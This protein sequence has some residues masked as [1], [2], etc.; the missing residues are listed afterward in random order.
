VTK[1]SFLLALTLACTPL[2]ACGIAS[3]NGPT[4]I[5]NTTAIDEKAMYAA[6]ASYNVIAQIYVTADVRGKLTPELKA[7]IKPVLVSA[8]NALKLARA[9]YE[10]GN[11]VGFL[12]EVNTLNSLGTTIANLIP[13]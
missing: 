10:A 6:E 5:A 13:K 12:H 4:A 3:I 8:Y 9:A 11:A 7:A 1:K 2:S